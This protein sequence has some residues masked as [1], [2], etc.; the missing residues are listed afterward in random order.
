MAVVPLSTATTVGPY[1]LI[2]LPLYDRNGCE[3]L[4]VKFPGLEGRW[5][6]KVKAGNTFELEWLDRLSSHAIRSCVEFPPADS[7]APLSGTLESGREWLAMRRYDC[8]IDNTPW[9]RAR[10]KQIGLAVLDFLEDIHTKLRSVHMDIKSYNILA[11]KTAETFHVCDFEHMTHMD[12]FETDLVLRHYTP[13]YRWYYTMLGGDPDQPFDSWRIDFEALAFVLAWLTWPEGVSI[14]F[15]DECRL[16]MEG[17][18]T[19][20]MTDEEVVEMREKEMADNADPAVQ[21][22]R[23]AIDELSWTQYEPPPAAFY[24]RLR[25]ILKG[26]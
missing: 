14:G 20:T 12:D 18:G 16:R 2:G 23:I 26:A 24:E 15:A 9:C 11:N 19:T 4:P 3:I 8:C 7:G 21:Q 10:W 22:L 13:E 1:Q 17:R 5:V 25:G 6:L